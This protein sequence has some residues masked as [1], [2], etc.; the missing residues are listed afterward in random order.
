MSRAV[1]LVT[2]RAPQDYASCSHTSYVRTHGW[3]AMRA[4][5]EVHLVCLARRPGSTSCGYGEVHAAATPAQLVRQNMIALHSPRLARAIAD[6]VRRRGLR[7]VILH[8]FGLWGH[9]VAAARRRL[10]PTGVRCVTLLG[11]YTSYLDESLSQWR[12]LG[13]ESGLGAAARFALEQAWIR[14]VVLPYERRA[15]R[16]ADRVLVNYRSVQRL[17]AARFGADIRCDIIPYSIEKEFDGGPLPPM[18]PPPMA[19]PPGATSPRP[20]AILSIARHD[21]R[22]GVDV[23]LRALGMLRQTGIAFSA[24]LLGSGVL[25]ERH[26][27]LVHSLGLGDR[28]EIL[29][30][31]PSVD[32]YLAEADLFVLP[33]REEQ[34]GSIA[35]LEAMRAGIAG[36]ASGCDG[37]PEDVRHGEDAWLTA[38]G[39]AASLAAGIEALIADPELRRRLALAGRRTFEA[40]FS[41]PAFTGSLDRLYQGLLSRSGSPA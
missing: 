32:P 21:P 11:S 16:D 14:S 4:G 40:R 1:I 26:R 3:A 12:G 41:G 34:S 24:R 13:A 9:A 36:I 18:A 39:D 28:V 38:P 2:G 15:Y 27:R 29:G 8:G 7:E 25:I 33:S 30:N 23:L 22:K 20:P 6:L 35:L 37:I 31:V 17:I 5:Y 19:R 10:R